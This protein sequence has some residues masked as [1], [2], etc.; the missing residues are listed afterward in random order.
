MEPPSAT[1]SVDGS[2]LLSNPT[3]CKGVGVATGCAFL[4]A[5]GISCICVFV[6][7]LPLLPVLL[8]GVILGGALASACIWSV[9]RLKKL[10][11]E[12]KK[13]PQQ[14][15]KPKGPT[16]EEEPPGPH[17]DGGQERLRNSTRPSEF[18][19]EE[20]PLDPVFSYEGVDD[21][22]GD[23][24]KTIDNRVKVPKIAVPVDI[25]DSGVADKLAAAQSL[26]FHSQQGDRLLFVCSP[27]ENGSKG[28]TYFSV[29]ATE[30]ESVW[31]KAGNVKCFRF[32]DELPEDFQIPGGQLP[33][34]E[35]ITFFSDSI[36]KVEIAN[37]LSGSF[38]K[39]EQ[40]VFR[41]CNN[42]R[43]AKVSGSW[44]ANNLQYVGFET[45]PIVDDIHVGNGSEK[46]ECGQMHAYPK[47]GD[48]GMSNG[49]LDV[50]FWDCRKLSGEQKL[51]YAATKITDEGTAWVNVGGGCGDSPRIWTQ[52][53][54]VISEG[55]FVSKSGNVSTVSFQRPDIST[56]NVWLGCEDLNS[57]V[58]LDFDLGKCEFVDF[59]YNS[60]I[61]HIEIAKA[62]DGCIISFEAAPNGVQLEVN[63]FP[64]QSTDCPGSPFKMSFATRKQSKLPK[65]KLNNVDAGNVAWYE[66]SYC[67]GKY[68]VPVSPENIE[69]ANGP[70]WSA[71]GGGD[72]WDQEVQIDLRSD[73]LSLGP[74]D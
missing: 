62:M 56:A 23:L 49:R 43:S 8:T 34:L 50:Q 19:R 45:C 1:S 60:E 13:Q 52:H 41:K 25:N 42:L 18:K 63:G 53:G 29:P 24:T 31:E 3:F 17:S 65:V 70:R 51:F 72:N 67:G 73:F 15:P 30:I 6:A 64:K 14:L 12:S 28:G 27:A 4:V 33:N 61:E 74:A 57:H 9:C 71:Y 58:K 44:T 20:D 35:R 54:G 11:E 38:E 26:H 37:H 66:F 40:I 47:E 10:N 36:A 55:S 39:L 59:P 22:S 68:L 16:G 5:A 48:F 69:K 32:L 7:A 46:I 21:S 2:A